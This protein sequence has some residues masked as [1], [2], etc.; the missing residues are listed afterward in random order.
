M[1]KER[2]EKLIKKLSKYETNKW[3]KINKVIK[4]K[5]HENQ[6][7]FKKY[8]KPNISESSQKLALQRRNKSRG[9]ISADKSSNRDDASAE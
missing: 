8:F 4:E 6:K 3:E 7:K 2:E 1:S 5:E 9:L